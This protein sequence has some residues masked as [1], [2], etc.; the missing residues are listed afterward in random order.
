MFQNIFFISVSNQ[1]DAEKIEDE[2]FETSVDEDPSVN[3]SDEEVTVREA[4]PIPQNM[5]KSTVDIGMYIAIFDEKIL[6]VFMF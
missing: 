4:H 3:N 1:Q 2:K 5:S 6:N